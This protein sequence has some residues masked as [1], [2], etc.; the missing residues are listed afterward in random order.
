MNFKIREKLK[1][2]EIVVIIYDKLK[3]IYYKHLISDE[4]LLRKLFKKKLNRELNLKTP[5][6]YNDKL[7]WLKL[8]W[9]DPNATIC[10]D[11]Y[12]VR[13]YVK[14]KIGAQYLNELYGV[15]DSVDE[16][17]IDKLPNKFV[18][19]GTHGSGF[20][21]ISKNKSEMN[22][23]KEFK[24]MRRWLRTKYYLQNREYVYKDIKPRI[25]IEKF[26]ETKND[27]PLIDYKFFCF[28]GEPKALFICKNRGLNTTFDFY[29]INWNYLDI[30]NYYPNSGLIEK[31]PEKLNEMLKLAE[32]LSKDFPHARVD[33]Y[34]ENNQIIFGEITFFHFSGT[35]NFYPKSFEK[36]MGDWL[37]LSKDN[38]LIM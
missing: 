23:E 17:D 21:I 27:A 6:Y 24:K 32:I 38:N 29:D 37:I 33:F 5:T 9:Q 16:I 36:E 12:D 30:K 10:A 8:N 31:K 15:Y 4:R 19:K 3:E 14:E 2:I 28:N 20:N 26:I 11:K 18:I 1:D 7:Q 34:Y 22:W 25:I 13:K 35:K